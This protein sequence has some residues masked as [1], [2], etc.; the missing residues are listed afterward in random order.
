MSHFVGQPPFSNS[1]W[2]A[3]ETIAFSHNPYQILLRT[4]SFRIQG[5]QINNLAS[6]K[7]CPGVQGNLNWF[8][9]EMYLVLKRTVNDTVLMSTH[10]IWFS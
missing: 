8:P 9:G 2:V 4:P 10:N 3:I 7:K 1:L 6:M 5:V